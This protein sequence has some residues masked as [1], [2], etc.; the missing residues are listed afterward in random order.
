MTRKRIFA[1]VPDFGRDL[2]DPVDLAHVLDRDARAR[3]DRETEV[4]AGLAAAVDRDPL[5]VDAGPQRALQLLGGVDVSARALVGQDL[6]GREQRVG[7]EGRQHVD[8]PVRPAGLEGGAEATHV[9]PQLRLG[10]HEQRRAVLLGEVA[11][12][13]LLDE[14]PPVRGC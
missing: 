6:S 4:L 5:G 7:L 3:L 12:G 10:E 14:Q 1:V 9:G 8:W 13:H 11:G 2:V